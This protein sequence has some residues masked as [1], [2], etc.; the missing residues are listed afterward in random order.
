[1][2]YGLKVS[3]IFEPLIK[4]YDNKNGLS[5][6]YIIGIINDIICLKWLR[7]YN[8]KYKLN[9]DITLKQVFNV[10]KKIING[11]SDYYSKKFK[12]FIIS[13]VKKEEFFDLNCLS[14]N[15][16]YIF[17]KSS[18]CLDYGFEIMETSIDSVS[19]DNYTCNSK[20]IKFLDLLGLT[21]FSRIK[22]KAH[23]DFNFYLSCCKWRNIASCYKKIIVNGE[24][25]VEKPF[26]ANDDLRYFFNFTVR[27][28]DIIDIEFQFKKFDLMAYIKMKILSFKLYLSNITK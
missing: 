20:Y 6:K 28:G 19:T 24:N 25:I 23:G 13:K 7:Y 16:C 18:Y 1:M 11:N 21:N 8:K 26:Y 2:H 4:H 14:S 12:N 3:F 22:L 10:L 17:P 27:N 9:S 15:A 5:K